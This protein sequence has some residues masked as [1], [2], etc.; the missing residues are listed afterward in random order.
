MS[1]LNPPM[2]GRHSSSGLDD[3]APDGSFYTARSEE[4]GTTPPHATGACSPPV[5]ASFSCAMLWCRCWRPCSHHFVLWCSRIQDVLK[6]ILYTESQ[7]CFLGA[8]TSCS[9]DRTAQSSLMC[10]GVRS[11]GKTAQAVAE[12]AT[13]EDED[14]DSIGLPMP[15]CIPEHSQSAETHEAIGVRVRSPS[16]QAHPAPS[17]AAAAAVDGIKELDALE[18]RSSSPRR[19]SFNLGESAAAAGLA[20]GT[21]R[22]PQGH[23]G[24]VSS[25]SSSSSDSSRGFCTTC[26]HCGRPDRHSSPRKVK[27]WETEQEYKALFWFKSPRLMLRIFQC[28]PPSFL[29]VFCLSAC[30]SLVPVQ[31]SGAVALALSRQDFNIES[32]P[33]LFLRRHTA[34]S[35]WWFV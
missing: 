13:K 33:P 3:R 28:A 35:V 7:V 20:G 21:P 25:P 14:A 5:L 15:T 22:S 31:F 11:S 8:V 24:K 30:P 12:A 10:A 34:R 17:P 32:A 9:N 6:C 29:H 18:D 26:M 2:G 23:V 19:S 27:K 1:G 4:P 16:K